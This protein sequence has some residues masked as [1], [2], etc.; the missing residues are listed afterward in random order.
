MGKNEEKLLRILSGELSRGDQELCPSLE[1]I[2]ALIDGTL[3]KEIRASVQNH[4]ASCNICYETFITASELKKSSP[5]T[6]LRIFPPWAIAATVFIA[7]VS[8]AIFFNVDLSEKFEDSEG[9]ELIA[10]APVLKEDSFTEKSKKQLNEIPEK[11]KIDK[12]KKKKEVSPVEGASE[13]DSDEQLSTNVVNERQNIKPAGRSV[14][15]KR[16]PASVQGINQ[17]VNEPHIQYQYEVEEKEQQN[18]ISLSSEYKRKRAVVGKAGGKGLV[19][20]LKNSRDKNDL[21]ADMPDCFRRSGGEYKRR[22]GFGAEIA[23]RSTLPEIRKLVQPGN[24]KPDDLSVPPV[25]LTLEIYAGDNGAVIKAC[26]VNG[27]SKYLREIMDS[28][29]KWEFY[30]PEKSPAR[31]RIVIGI[32]GNWIVEVLDK[33]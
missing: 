26:L 2:S 11:G 13:K 30:I 29:K 4:I 3:K 15:S 6:S 10:S 16:V 1:D 17:A 21:S 23:L 24:K 14:V 19:D 32:I 25:Y 22:E 20:R 12:S 9:P 7:L 33:I 18:K 8:F 28:V 31:F 27:S 5:H